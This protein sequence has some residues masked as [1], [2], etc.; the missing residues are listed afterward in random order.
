MVLG[1]NLKTMKQGEILNIKR[2]VMTGGD[3]AALNPQAKLTSIING[4]YEDKAGQIHADDLKE[5][6]S[7]TSQYLS[8]DSLPKNQ[9]ELERMTFIKENESPMSTL[10]SIPIEHF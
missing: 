3:S 8:G 9:M 10:C 6:E 2:P 7:K 1:A 5:L 4:D